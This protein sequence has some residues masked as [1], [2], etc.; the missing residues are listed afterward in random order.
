MDPTVENA[1][2][3]SMEAFFVDSAPA[4]AIIC[5]VVS[6]LG[7]DPRH[8]A[9]VAYAIVAAALGPGVVLNDVPAPFNVI[10]S[11]T[12]PRTL[13]WFDALIAPFLGT[14]FDM[15]ADLMRNPS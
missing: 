10:V 1:P 3:S 13:P 11:H 14:V 12:A 9:G 8:V 15:Q 6:D 4:P 2:I 7:S 5:D